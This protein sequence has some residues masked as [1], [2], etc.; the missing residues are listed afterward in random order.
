MFKKVLAVML[1]LTMVFSVGA[2]AVSGADE[3]APS[4]NGNVF[5]FIPQIWQNFSQIYC[6]IYEYDGD[7]LADWQAKAEKCVDNGDGTWTYDLDAKGFSLDAGTCYCIMFSTNTMCETYPC[8]MDTT[9]FGDTLYLTGNKIENPV[10]SSKSSDE[11][12]FQNHD[13]NVYGPV[14]AI[15]SIGNVVGHVLPSDRSAYDLFVDFLKNTLPNARMFSGKDDQTLLDDIGRELGLTA[16]AVERAIIESGVTTEWS[17][18]KSSLPENGDQYPITPTESP[19]PQPTEATEPASTASYVFF[20]MASAGWRDFSYIFCHIYEYNGDSFFDWHMKK[21]RCEDLGNGIYRYSLD[22]K[23][24]TLRPDRCYCVIFA[25][26]L[27]RQ[28]FPLLMDTTCLGDT[29][30]MTGGMIENPVDSNKVCFEAYWKSQDKRINGPVLTITSIGNVVGITCAPCTTPFEMFVKFLR[31]DLRNA[32]AY[33]GK[34][35]QRLLDDIGEALGLTADD[36]E[37]AL[38]ESGASGIGWKKE[39]SPLPAGDPHPTEPPA[40]EPTEAPT[41]A[42]TEPEIMLGDVDGDGVVSVL[43]A[44]RIQKFK[45]KL[46]NLDGDKYDGAVTIVQLRTADVD[47]DGFISVMDATRIQKYKAKLMN[48]DGSTPYT[49]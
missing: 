6:H 30:V 5:H 21:E 13:K 16:G 31:E 34:D 44:T 37:K 38:K 47:S 25:D 17:I 10:D 23:G 40:T 2:V 8:L 20:D 49:G 1:A 19:Y 12:V 41:E 43:D 45:A 15:T 3:I 7:H 32:R 18:D 28:T 42:P 26:D 22:E 24:I 9:C 36:V 11:A 29:A 48:L 39:N 35:D 4:G 46:L 14:L 33:S 27:G